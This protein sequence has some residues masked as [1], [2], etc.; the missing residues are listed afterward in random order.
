MSKDIVSTYDELVD[1]VQEARYRYYVLSD[2]G[3]SDQDFD[4][5][6]KKLEQLEKENPSLIRPDSPTQQVGPP[7][8][9]AFLPYRHLAPMQSLDNAFNREELDDFFAR[10]IQKIGAQKIAYVC[11]PKIDGVAINLIYRKSVLEKAI[12]RGN[13]TVGE[14]VTLQVR[15]IVDVPKRLNSARNVDLIEIRGEIYFPLKEF[16]E[17]NEARIAEGEAAFMNPRNAASGALRQKDPSITAKRPLRFLAHSLGGAYSLEGESTISLNPESFFPSHSDFLAWA[18]Q[19][20]FSVPKPIKKAVSS[21][22][23]W[24]AIEYFTAERHN[25]AY[26]ID[27]VVIKV[28]E[29]SLH[30]QLGSTARA[31]RW[32]IAYKIPAL[33]KET[34]LISIEVN[35]G[36]TGKVTPYAVLEPVTLAGVTIS[37]ATLHNEDQIHLKDVREGDTVIVR[38][39]GDVIPEVVKAITERRPEN[40]SIWSMPERCPF[41]HEPLVKPL[42]EANHYCENIDCPNRVVESLIHFCSKSAMDIETLGEKT[43]VV[44]HDMGILSNVA[45]IFKL[46]VSVPVLEN[47]EGWGSKKIDNL[48][49]AIENSKQKPLD[50]LLVALNIRHVG[51]VATKELTAHFPTLDSIRHAGREQLCMISG[52][53][54]KIADSLITWFSNKNNSRLL[55]ELTEL[56]V[57]T[58]VDIQLKKDDHTAPL[59]GKTFVITGTFSGMTRDEI[60][61][62]LESMGAKTTGSVS[63]NT[64]ALL[65]GSDPGGKLEKAISLGVEIMR[66]GDLEKLFAV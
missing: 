15:T 14:D 23:T 5:L 9:S 2:P 54:E 27:G 24:Q 16:A 25:F 21:D 26:E 30:Q 53:G 52:V 12:T 45:D 18:D 31:P 43:I 6:F 4:A 7:P 63:K 49:N 64:T 32:A 47:L 59:A 61:E 60:K 22:E 39:A 46:H 13:G 58:D 56:G 37:R 55:E 42:G 1:A 35:V 20:G 48:L 8:G 36:R 44:L 38:R 65:V 29:L 33:E 28:D 41:C 11:E 51:S 19:A 62:K 34:K 57:R 66:E 10:I 3:M 17:M 40:L 50:R